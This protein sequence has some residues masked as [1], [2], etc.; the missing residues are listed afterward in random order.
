MRFAPS[1]AHRAIRMRRSGNRSRAGDW[2]IFR[3]VSGRKMCLSPSRP[4]GQSHFRGLRRENW[5][6]PRERLRASE[7]RTTRCLRLRFRLPLR[8]ESSGISGCAALFA[9][10]RAIGPG[11]NAGPNTASRKRGVN[12]PP[13]EIDP[14]RIAQRPIC[15]QAI[16]RRERSQTYRRPPA[17]FAVRLG[18]LA[19][20]CPLNGNLAIAS[21]ADFAC[22]RGQRA[23]TGGRFF[24]LETAR[25]AA[26][27][28]SLPIPPLLPTPQGTRRSE[29]SLGQGNPSFRPKSRASA[30]DPFL[31]GEYLSR[32]LL[33]NP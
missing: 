22:G 4:R 12:A 23:G 30:L 25:V 3:A 2:H 19:P 31:P 14:C 29:H 9:T 10:R 26:R 16:G 6:S 21:Q 15:T 8:R 5:D 17:R 27:R 20:P 28:S 24:F 33:P 32:S 11:V 7:G 18:S 13:T 1:I